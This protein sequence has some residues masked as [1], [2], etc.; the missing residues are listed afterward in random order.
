MTTTERFPE[1]NQVAK[2]PDGRWRAEVQS[3]SGMVQRRHFDT[4]GRALSWARKMAQQ[5]TTQPFWTPELF[6]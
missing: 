2:L 1:Y 6:T 3:S 5:M 4:A